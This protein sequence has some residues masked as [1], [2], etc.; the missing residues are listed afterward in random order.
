MFLVL[1]ARQHVSCGKRAGQ[2]QPPQMHH[3]LPR[4]CMLAY[5]LPSG[6]GVQILS[7]ADQATQ[8]SNRV[9]MAQQPL[10]AKRGRGR[11]LYG[12]FVMCKLTRHTETVNAGVPTERARPLSNIR[13]TH[14]GKRRGGI[15]EQGTPRSLAQ[16]APHSGYRNFV[17]CLCAAKKAG[18]MSRRLFQSYEPTI[19]AL[20]P[21]CEP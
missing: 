8:P 19:R 11:S 15:E 5:L 2:R 12:G 4:A 1:Q 7:D 10:W 14:S 13:N 20:V 18:I 17:L 3:T 21:R 9:H 6:S 16:R